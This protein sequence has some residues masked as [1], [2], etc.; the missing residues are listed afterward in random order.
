M[1]AFLTATLVLS[2]GCKR[3]PESLEEWRNARGG[4]DQL[5]E[6]ASSDSESMEVRIRAIQ[7][8]IEEG[9]DDRLPRLLDR[10]E[11]EEIRQQLADGAM[12]TIE[13]MWA[14]QDMP[15][16]TDEI[17]QGGGNVAV[18]DSKSILAKDAAYR[19]HPY[20]GD[21]NRQ[22]LEEILRE[23]M[24]EDQELRTQLGGATIPVLLPRAGSG[25]VELLT[26]WI[27]ETYDPRDTA[28]RLRRHASESDMRVIDAAV[29]E[30]AM[31]EHPE[32]RRETQHAVN[33]AESDGIVPYLEMAILDDETPD[34]FLPA[35]LE[36]LLRVQGEDSVPFFARLITER[37]GILR[38]VAANSIIDA[39]KVDG[40]VDIARALPSDVAS[41]EDGLQRF[42]TQTCNYVNLQIEREEITGYAEP[43][44][45]VLAMETWPAQLLG[46]QCASRTQSVELREQ[47]QALRTQRQVIPHWEANT[48][49]GQMA[50]AVDSQLG[51]V[52]AEQ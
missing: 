18:G 44:G 25:A 49:I 13:S 36:T 11:D 30:R 15:E 45:E 41:Y 39:K 4:I 2:I 38:W 24:S 14:A 26:E 8:I 23:W 16:L 19:L 51:T 47:V 7:I 10:I 22:R 1:I 42:V 48:T 35:C 34:D 43:I 46:L 31:A 3:T 50:T 29:S 27:K 6:W 40:L 32:L 5:G 12:S 33:E 21:A 52:A 20:M 37:S 9:Q 28:G 17:R